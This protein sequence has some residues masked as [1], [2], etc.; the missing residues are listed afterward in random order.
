MLDDV[1]WAD[2]ASLE[3]IVHLLRR[4]APARIL[5][6]LAFR[7]GQLPPPV[8]AAL[9]AAQTRRQRARAAA[10]RRSRRTRRR[11]CWA[12]RRCRGRVPP[13]GGNPF[14]L[15][16]LAREL[17]ERDVPASV[18][19]ALGQEIEALERARAPAGLGR[20]GGRR[21]RRLELATTAA[22][23]HR[24]R[25]AGRARGADP[26]RRPARDRGP[27]PLRLPPP[28]V[29]GAVYASA[30]EA[31]RLHA[32]ARAAA[33]LVDRPSALAARAHHVERSAR[34]G[35]EDGRGRARAGRPQASARA[36]AVAARWLAAALRALPDDPSHEGR[37]LGMLVSLAER[38]GRDRPPRR[39]ARDAA[40]TLAGSAPSRPTLRVRLIAACASCENALGR[41][42][43][44]HARLLHAL[45]G[46]ARRRRPAG[47][48]RRRR[49]LRLRLRR[50][51]GMGRPRPRGPRARWRPGPAGR[52][53]GAR[54]LRRLRPRQAGAGRGRRARPAPPRSTRSRTSCSPPA[55]SAALPRLRGVL[56]RALRRTRHATS[57]AGSRSRARSG[58]GSSWSR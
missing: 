51:G 56:L 24:G 20:G 32:H 46:R 45:D 50:D 39:G 11:S 42:G 52:R 21:S 48:A 19:A 15:Q 34:A 44:A 26:A 10:R 23:L 2:E 28:V 55:G 16:E 29:R 40:E 9:E 53:R 1:H 4:P 12:R 31:W 57:G 18:A 33:A 37:R 6:A 30:G 47:R 14:Y 8:L 58:R 49:A 22:G 5:I 43:A 27:A 36:P 54:V 41:H 38:A 25:R 7:E 3:L 13:S 35:D 17:A